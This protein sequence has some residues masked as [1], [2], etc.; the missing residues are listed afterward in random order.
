MSKHDLFTIAYAVVDAKND[1]NW[2][3]FC[4]H[5]RSVLLSHQYIPFDEFTF[6]SDRHP[7]IIKAVNQLFFGS[8]HAYCL[9]HLVDNFVKQVLRSYPRHNKKHW[10]LVFKKAAYAPSF[11]EYEQHINSIFESMPLA[12]RFILNSDP[13]S[14]ANALFVGNRWGVINNNIAECWNSWVRPALHLPIVGMVDHIRVQIMSMMHRMRESTLSMNKELS[15]RKEKS[16]SSVY[17][18]SRTLRVHR[19][20]NWKFE[21]VDGEKLFVVDLAD[22]TCSCRVWYFKIEMYRAVYK[23]II[24]PIPTFD[25]S[26]EKA[27]I[28]RGFEHGIALETTYTFKRK[29][30]RIELGLR[31]LWNQQ[32]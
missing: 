15:P 32:L 28:G 18:E 20:C 4:Y 27:I 11:Q 10:S 17:I 19:S 12:R 7:S 5:L 22:R 25:T 16:V 30:F 21:V 2:D 31:H 24:N 26:E 1:V 23:G 8:G 3:W 14:W 9:R 29:H 6:F 13:Q